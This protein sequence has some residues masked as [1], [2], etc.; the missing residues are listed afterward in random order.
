MYLVCL[1]I[2]GLV[3]V[4][5]YPCALSECEK[6]DESKGQLHLSLKCVLLCSVATFIIHISLCPPLS[7]SIPT[8]CP[9][10]AL[11]QPPCQGDRLLGRKGTALCN[12]QCRGREHKQQHSAEFTT[13]YLRKNSNRIRDEE[14]TFGTQGKTKKDK[15]TKRQRLAC[16][17]RVDISHFSLNVYLCHLALSFKHYKFSQLAVNVPNNDFFLS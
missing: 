3:V 13:L 14:N 12:K 15:K 17:C 5:Q 10:R 6:Q 8:L 2:C 1:Q 16:Q 11:L 9:P 7:F 4:C